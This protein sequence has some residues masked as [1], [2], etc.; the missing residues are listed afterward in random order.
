MI[1]FMIRL[2]VSALVICTS[3]SLARA[4]MAGA[5]LGV[6]DHSD[7]VDRLPQLDRDVVESF[8]AIDGRAE[9]R[10]RPTQLRIV[11][12]VSSEGP[13][14]QECQRIA[15][16]TVAGLKNRWLKLQIPPDSIVEDFIAVLPVHEWNLEKRG[17]TEVGVEQRVGFRMQSNIHLALP[18]DATAP[19]ALNAAFEQGITDI[20]AFDYWNEELDAAKVQARELALRAARSKSDTLL[21]AL[22]EI[23]PAVINVQEQTTVR[24]P[25]T[26]YHSFENSY[27]E[28]VTPAW[29]NN[30]RSNVPFI[31]AY[32][33]RNTYYRGLASDGDI[34]SVGLP[35]HP[36]ILV[37][38]TVRLYYES[39]AAIR[40]KKKWSVEPPI[41]QEREV[42]QGM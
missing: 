11:L 12:A 4:Q 42:V 24:Y 19:T 25:E 2:A 6:E 29:V 13:T 27:Q 1:S 5:R 34:Q 23:R 28:E 7:H 36:E 22:F 37:V 3:F 40:S 15:Q 26:L 20:I 35:M 8:I 38:S 17:D 9:V 41:E 30:Q 10:V 14:A 31:R 33:P 32:R 21:K 16:E 39:P 18:N